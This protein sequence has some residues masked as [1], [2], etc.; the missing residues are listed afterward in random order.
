[1][2]TEKTKNELL[3][4]KLSDCV[5]NI[6]DL[7][8]AKEFA[9]FKELEIIAEKIFSLIPHPVLD[10]KLIE[11]IVIPVVFEGTMEDF[12]E[13]TKCRETKYVLAR[14]FVFMFTKLLTTM[15]LS[16]MGKQYNKDH[17]TVL[18]GINTLLSQLYLAQNQQHFKNIVNNFVKKGYYMPDKIVKLVQ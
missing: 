13:H 11:E 1:M 10:F 5:D 18:T 15:S 17:A 12:R 2:D 8:K 16:K 7:V 9:E 6:K 3:L 14:A 4:E